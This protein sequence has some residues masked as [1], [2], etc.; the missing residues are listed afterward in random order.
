MELKAVSVLGELDE[1]SFQSHLY[2]I[3]SRAAERAGR[4]SDGFN[5]TFMELKV[6]RGQRKKTEVQMFQSHLYGI[7][8]DGLR[9]SK[10]ATTVS[11]T[12]LWN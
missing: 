5:R 12:P 7:E 8:R 1:L 11:I 2:G 3:E 9:S 6:L 10:I 4:M